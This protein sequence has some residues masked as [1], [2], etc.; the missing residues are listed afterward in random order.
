LRL[1]RTPA[2]DYIEQTFGED[3]RHRSTFVGPVMLRMNEGSTGY[4]LY[5]EHQDAEKLS[6]R[7]KVLEDLIDIVDQE[8]SFAAA[9]P[10]IRSED[11]WSR[12]HPSVKRVSRSRFEARHYADAVEAALKELNTRDQGIRP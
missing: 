6:Y 9:Q 12:L 7:V 8:L 2:L 3:C 5:T 10:P 4:D 1:G 11:F